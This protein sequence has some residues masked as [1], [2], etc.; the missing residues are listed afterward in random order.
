LVND[1]ASENMTALEDLLAKVPEGQTSLANRV[2]S[3]TSNERDIKK[4]AKKMEEFS[5]QLKSGEINVR[6]GKWIEKKRKI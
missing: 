5:S 1:R 6:D 3:I 2:N 4:T